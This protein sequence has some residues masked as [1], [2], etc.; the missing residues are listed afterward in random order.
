MKLTDYVNEVRAIADNKRVSLSTAVG[1]FIVNLNVMK[2]FNHGSD[3]FNYRAIGQEWG[4]LPY[5]EKNKQ[6]N[7]LLRM[8]KEPAPTTATQRRGRRMTEG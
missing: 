7:A 6:R 8:V 4:R 5:A 3:N 2:D 1:M